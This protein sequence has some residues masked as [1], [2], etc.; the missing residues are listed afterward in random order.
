M[1]SENAD[2]MEFCLFDPKD[3]D[4][5]VKTVPMRRDAN[6]VVTHARFAFGGMAATPAR[7]RAAEKVL[8]DAALDEYRRRGRRFGR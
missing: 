1:F 4:W 3:P 6:G 5:R 7:A 2:A 8:L